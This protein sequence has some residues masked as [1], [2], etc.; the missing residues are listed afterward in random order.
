[1]SWLPEVV[2]PVSAGIALLVTAGLIVAAVMAVPRR[3]VVARER[4]HG[5]SPQ[6][7]ALERTTRT[8]TALISRAVG[9]GGRARSWRYALDRAGIRR[10]LPDFVLMVGAATLAGVAIGALLGGAW[11]AVLFGVAVPLLTA[12]YVAIRADRR[13]A[14]FGDQLDD[15]CQLL[16]TNLRAGHSLVQSLSALAV[17]VEEPAR[18]ELSRAVNQVRVGRDLGDALGE[19]AER[20]GSADFSWI[21]QAIAI[22]RQVGGNLADVLDT[23]ALTIR[24]RNQI[25]RQARSL[26]A[27]GR[28]SAW[29]LV[30]LP[31]LLALALSILNPIYLEVFTQTRIGLLMLLAC[32]VMMSIGS[33]WLSRLVK[34][35]Y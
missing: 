33:L 25:R 9:R 31:I 14:Q 28:M 32:V 22:H 27:E 2:S 17:E 19:T 4:L 15:L 29:V 34:V 8:T 21:A 3:Q 12:V 20:M 35:E 10:D 23:V 13:K 11:L 7:S 24:E 30:G 5:P 26:S 6:G 16:A 18:S 1:M